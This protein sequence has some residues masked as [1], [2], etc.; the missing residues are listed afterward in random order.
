MKAEK[1]VKKMYV[2]C[3]L[4]ILFTLLYSCN[5]FANSCEG[6]L[7][8]AQRGEQTASPAVRETLV[9][10]AQ[11]RLEQD[12]KKIRNS[13]KEPLLKAQGLKPSYYAGVDLVREFNRVQ[14]YLEEIKA[15]P[16]Q[17]HISYFADQATKTLSDFEKSFR[18]QNKENK[19]FLEERLKLLED[20]KTEARRKATAQE[21]TYYWWVHF[22]FRLAFLATHQDEIYYPLPSKANFIDHFRTHKDMDE[23]IEALHKNGF[24]LRIK[25]IANLP[26]T[27]FFSTNNFG[28]MAFNRLTNKT[29]IVG[30]SGKD[31]FDNAS[32]KS[33]LDYIVHDILH[34]SSFGI[35]H[36]R[37]TAKEFEKKRLDNISNKSD[38]EKVELIFFLLH[39]EVQP[40]RAEELK[41]FE[42]P[43]EKLKHTIRVNIKS[44]GG[45][46]MFEELLPDYLEITDSGYYNISDKKRKK[47]DLYI[48]EA[49]DQFTEVFS[50]LFASQQSLKK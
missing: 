29:H 48:D 45:W 33:P 49:V 47:L 6:G 11:R 41:I 5:S 12:L 34:I 35:P 42:E 2:F 20:F 10:N 8:I 14:E 23:A 26:E 15:D 21:V 43:A 9:Q 16:K 31:Q 32:R 50:D 25:K 30:V 19:E 13:P 22:N 7:S 1:K 39:H 3:K 38:R 18:E 4:L 17:T 46:G 44:I 37:D 36:L 28:I 40:F 24:D 27:L